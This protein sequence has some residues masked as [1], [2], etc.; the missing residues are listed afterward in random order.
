M[1]HTHYLTAHTYPATQ[2]CSATPWVP[3]AGNPWG[4]NRDLNSLNVAS[5]NSLGL[6]GEDRHTPILW[7]SRLGS[8]N[9]G[10]LGLTGSLAAL[11]Y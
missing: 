2:I 1:K 6:Q 10:V 11:F 5:N 4:Q 3:I 9:R 8:G 7:G